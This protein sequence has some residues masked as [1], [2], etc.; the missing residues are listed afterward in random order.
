MG[1]TSA[2]RYR[3]DQAKSVADGIDR[4]LKRINKKYTPHW[5]MYE[6]REAQ[7]KSQCVVGE[8][9]QVMKGY[10]DEL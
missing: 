1:A 8:F 6:L 2:R 4:I 10:G 7:H 5:M 3:R 9:E